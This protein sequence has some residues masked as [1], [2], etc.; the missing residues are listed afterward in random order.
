[1]PE[2]MRQMLLG[3]RQ[4]L[5]AGGLPDELIDATPGLELP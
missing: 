5:R 3:V 2:D 4:T 1:M